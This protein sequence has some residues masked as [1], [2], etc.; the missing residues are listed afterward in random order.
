[1][2]VHQYVIFLALLMCRFVPFAAAAATAGTVGVGCVV[3][4][5]ASGNVQMHFC[6]ISGLSVLCI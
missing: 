6:T 3:L 2:L 4:H 1:M 5:S